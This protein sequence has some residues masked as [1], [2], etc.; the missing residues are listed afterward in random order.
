[1]LLSWGGCGR[2][3][4]L[5]LQHV[6]PALICIKAKTSIRMLS[7]RKAVEQEDYDSRC[8]LTGR[9]DMREFLAAAAIAVVFAGAAFLLPASYD[10]PVSPGRA[11][12][13]RRR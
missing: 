13:F 11:G 9:A 12:R 1:M 8:S 3:G 4:P 6:A 5:I 10:R 2:F 7:S